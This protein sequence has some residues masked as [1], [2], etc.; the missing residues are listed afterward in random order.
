[1]PSA[2]RLRED[3]SAEELRTHARRS[4]DVRTPNTSLYRPIR[5]KLV[6]C[7]RLSAFCRI[8]RRFPNFRDIKPQI[9]L[10]PLK[11]EEKFA[12]IVED[13]IRELVPLHRGLDG[14]KLKGGLGG[15]RARPESQC[16]ARRP[17][18]A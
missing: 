11:D 5:Y 3:Y 14:F 18:S 16:C 12:T 8:L 4:K 9:E 17:G 6:E 1:M 13:R 2:V 10:K 7:G 15:P